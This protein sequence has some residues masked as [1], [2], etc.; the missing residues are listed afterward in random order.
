LKW[1]VFRE[2]RSQATIH[3]LSSRSGLSTAIAPESGAERHEGPT[4]HQADA[5][6]RSLPF[7]TAFHLRRPRGGQIEPRLAAWTREPPNHVSRSASG[8]PEGDGAAGGGRAGALPSSGFGRA[9]TTGGEGAGIHPAVPSAAIS[10]R[11]RLAK[12]GTSRPVSAK[13]SVHAIF[14]LLIQLQGVKSVVAG[15]ICR[16]RGGHRP[17]WA[18]RAPRQPR[19]ASATPVC[20]LRCPRRDRRWRGETSLRSPLGGRL[21]PVAARVSAGRASGA[22]CKA[23]LALLDWNLPS[24][25]NARRSE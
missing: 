15:L 23:A 19:Q 22:S 4:T 7:R 17:L 25:R 12:R 14:P 24:R 13:V 16:Q 6:G 5:S 9:V 20:G 3:H 1:I 2:C 21:A 10:V 11:C 18:T 8:E